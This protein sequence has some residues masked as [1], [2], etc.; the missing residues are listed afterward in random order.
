MLLVIDAYNVLKLIQRTSYVNAEQHK[1]F[2]NKLCA[3]AY[4]KKH[5]LIVVFDGGDYNRPTIFNYKNIKTV[6]S[7]SNYSADDY[8]K[9]YVSNL[10]NSIKTC[11][12]LVVSSDLELCKYI[13]NFGV[14]CLEAASF[15]NFL[16]QINLVDSINKKAAIKSSIPAQKSI[17]YES[18]E[19]LDA[20]MRESS[21]NVI[22]K[23]KDKDQDQEKTNNKSSSR[24]LSKYD[25]KINKLIK[26]L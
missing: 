7:G 26:K 11:E 24:E 16:N 8:I 23:D 14:S 17:G 12:V 22:I 18:T 10:K 1:I 4:I 25:K 19:E 13:S 6:Y 3:Y 20:I 15:V 21:E 5:E 2:L 9:D